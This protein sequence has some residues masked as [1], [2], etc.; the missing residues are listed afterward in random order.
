MSDSLQL[1]GLQPV[2]LLCEFSRQEY[3]SELPFPSPGDL[4][5]Q[6]LNLHPCIFCIGMWIL[7][8]VSCRG[9]PTREATTMRCLLTATTEACVPRACAPQQEK[10]SEW[11]GRAPQLESSHHSLQ[12]ENA[13]AQ[14]RRPRAAKNKIKSTLLY[15]FHFIH[16][17]LS[18][19]SVLCIRGSK[20]WSFSLS[21]IPSNEYSELISFRIDWLDLLAVQGTLKNLLQHHSSK[22]SVLWQ[23]A[24]FMVKLSHPC[25]TIG[26]TVALTIQ[27]FVCKVMSLLFNMLSRLVRAFLPRSKCLLISWC[28]HHLQWFWNPKK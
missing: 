10:L 24:F 13:H 28:S 9:N 19:E 27:T 8:Q 21:I 17:G 15:T 4:P 7:Y 20:Y 22:A 1:H 12:L 14:Q 25:M 5:A 23:S 16:Q 18:Y 2:R 11:E 3:W 26:K 6:G